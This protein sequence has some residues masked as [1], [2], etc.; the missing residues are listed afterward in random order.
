MRIS[1]TCSAMPIT[2]SKSRSVTRHTL[3]VRPLAPTYILFQC[4]IFIIIIIIILWDQIELLLN[5]KHVCSL[6][7]FMKFKD[8][9]E[10][11]GCRWT[12]GYLALR[13]SGVHGCGVA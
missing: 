12:G 13:F 11:R 2:S 4:L 1:E 6:I 7:F 8:Q 10:H 3:P 5:S 9:S